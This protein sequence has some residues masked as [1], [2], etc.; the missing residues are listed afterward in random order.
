MK[1]S[2][3]TRIA[4][5]ILFAILIAVILVLAY[6][7]MIP[8]VVG[9]IPFYEQLGHFFLFGMLA[10]LL[11]R[12]LKRRHFRFLG[13]AIPLGIFIIAIFT[14]AE[15]FLQQLSP[16]RTFSLSDLSF[17]LAGILAFYGIDRLCFRSLPKI[18]KQANK[19]QK[20]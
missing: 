11:H 2:N 10:W 5:F 8:R 9:Y 15:E 12:A 7:G 18:D 16:N 20:N 14:T 1:I 6:L 19:I 3:K 4:E 17:S 13:M